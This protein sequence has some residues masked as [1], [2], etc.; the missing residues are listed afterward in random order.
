MGTTVRDATRRLLRELGLTTVFGN[1]GTTEIPFLTEWPADFRY[2]LGLQESVVVAMADGYA[3]AARRPVLVNLHSAGGVGHALGQVFTA[4]RNRTPMVVLAGQQVR[5]L[6]PDEPFL[7]ATD[8]TLFP[9]PYV[10]WSCEPARAWDVPAA[11]ARAYRVAVQ[12][13]RGP[14]FVSVP[15]DDWDAE[16]EPLV[17]RPPIA[18]FA[19]DP[20]ALGELAAAVDA[21]RRPAYV[22]GPAVDAEGAV[23]DM[24]ALAER[25]R[26]GVWAAP[27]SP[28]CSFP[29]DHPL[30]LGWL[31]PERVAATEA[32]AAHDLVVVLGAPA[33]TYHVYRG[34]PDRSL[35]PLFLVSDDEQ[36]LAR[37]PEGRGIRATV[38]P[39]VRWL[40][41]AVGDGEPADRPAPAPRERAPRPAAES[42][43]TAAHVYATL[44]DLLPPGAIL[45]EETPSHRPELHDHLPITARDTG[46]L[47]VASGTLGYGLPAAV[48]AALARPERKV[49]AVLGDGSSMYGIQALWT[50]AT[51]HVP[52]TCVILDNAQYAAVRILGEAAGSPKVPGVDLGGIDFGALA[53]G[54]GCAAR[55]VSRPEELA[56][57]LTAALA[58]PAP[59]VLHV[60]VDPG[61]RTPY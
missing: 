14:T 25:T 1:P 22:V 36:V 37:A 7:G 47:T 61:A 52:L 20:D 48:G 39:T 10:K 29:E 6:L 3:Q 26:A 24:V 31:A 2:V 16:T 11:L 46:F 50:A 33:F 34:E 41:A 56:P 58:D 35:P 44:A 30:F 5:A 54:M 19:P 21:S 4:Y 8:A 13:P 17:A 53:R 12:P 49:V 23:D 9:R 15:A 55:R 57:A 45:V 18:G 28:R 59:N 32:L 51:E 42:P 38:A 27:M 40:A 60:E 43:L